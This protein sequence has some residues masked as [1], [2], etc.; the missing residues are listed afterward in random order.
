MDKLLSMLF[1]V[2]A[3]TVDV[4]A[5]ICIKKSKG[6]YNKFYGLAAFALVILCC[7]LLTAALKLLDLGMA[8]VLFGALGILLTT[9]VEVLFFRLKLRLPAFIGIAS[10]L[11]GITL[12]KL[13]S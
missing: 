8:Y 6:F 13:Y 12:L 7:V 10:L 1:I 11:G 9:L 5:N 3:V 2:G 4:L